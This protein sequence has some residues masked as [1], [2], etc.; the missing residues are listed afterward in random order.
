MPR[1]YY[2]ST[3]HSPHQQEGPCQVQ[4]LDLGPL[5]P[6][7]EEIILPYR[8]PSLWYVVTAIEKQTET[9]S[10]PVFIYYRKYYHK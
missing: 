10:L 2:L 8:L 4:T 3:Q 5:E 7:A 9:L 6:W 1:I